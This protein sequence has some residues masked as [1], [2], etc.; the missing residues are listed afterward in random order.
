VA[1]TI[2]GKGVSFM[3]DDN[4]WHYT[5]LTPDTYAAAVRELVPA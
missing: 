3:E 2:K 4:R 5:R 1:R